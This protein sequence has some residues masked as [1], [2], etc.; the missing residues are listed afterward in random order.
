VECFA[1]KKL[2]P[3]DPLPQDGSDVCLRFKAPLLDIESIQ[4]MGARIVNAEDRAV[5]L[6][7]AQEVGCFVN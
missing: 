7:N 5:N 3:E 6:T 2:N 4:T 1:L